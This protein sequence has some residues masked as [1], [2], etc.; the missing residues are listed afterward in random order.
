M[1]QC[2]VKPALNGKVKIKCLKD[3]KLQQE[4]G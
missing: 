4:D 1:L 2:Q 3:L